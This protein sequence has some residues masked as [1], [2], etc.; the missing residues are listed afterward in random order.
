M[1]SSVPLR[2]RLPSIIT[3][4]FKGCSEEN[5][6]AKKATEPDGQA[7]P[8]WLSYSSFVTTIDGQAVETGTVVDLPLTYY[9]PSIP[10]GDGWTYGGAASPSETGQASPSST[11]STSTSPGAIPSST[12]GSQSKSGRTTRPESSATD[13]S[14]GLSTSRST[15]SDTSFTLSSTSP[16]STLSSASGLPISPSSSSASSRS[17]TQPSTPSPSVTI[18]L[19]S[20]TPAVSTI[21]VASSIS[22]SSSAI[23]SFVP[24]TSEATHSDSSLIPLLPALLVPL[25]SL[26]VLGL[27]ILLC[28]CHRKRTHSGYNSTLTATA[29]GFGGWLTSSVTRTSSNRWRSA[30]TPVPVVQEVKGEPITLP[31]ETSALLPGFTAQHHRKSSSINILDDEF[32][33]LI[34][35]NQTLLE[36]LRLGLGFQTPSSVASSTK[37]KDKTQRIISGNTLE[38]GGGLASGNHKRHAR[39]VTDSSGNA[40]TTSGNKYEPLADEMLFFR[41]PI[42]TLSSKNSRS[43][44]E[45]VSGSGGSGSGNRSAGTGSRTR[46]MTPGGSNVRKPAEKPP[47]PEGAAE[48]YWTT[49]N[50]Q[51]FNLGIPET[52]ETGFY[53]SS[54]E[55]GSG[56]GPKW[57]DGG[58]RLD[59]PIPPDSAEGLGLEGFT[60][61]F[62]VASGETEYHSIPEGDA[63]DVLDRPSVSGISRQLPS[64]SALF[65]R[66]SDS[67][68]H[69]SVSAFGSHPSTPPN[70]S[71]NRERD[72]LHPSTSSQ[73]HDRKS[74]EKSTWRRFSHLFSPSDSSPR[75]SLDTAPSVQGEVPVLEPGSYGE[76]GQPLK[77]VTQSSPNLVSRS[78]HSQQSQAASIHGSGTTSSAESL[79]DMRT[80][81]LRGKRS[82]PQFLRASL[83]GEMPPLPGQQRLTA[84]ADMKEDQPNQEKT[85]N[86]GTA[87]EEKKGWF[88]KW[89]S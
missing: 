7:L 6:I 40:T 55:D 13:S 59:F 83:L 42:T 19:T 63:E 66:E 56:R 28:F 15:T 65:A 51:S 24:G 10:L 84:T 86:E 11:L 70:S 80:R 73:S 21:P 54:V 49:E 53:P 25:I 71:P 85:E 1:A 12:T 32:V 75:P 29:G 35:S 14:A 46:T 60:N 39:T 58:D 27:L 62:S 61:R 68:R 77:D 22:S 17:D 5:E 43:T 2:C 88:G 26:L 18:S 82:Q 64:S 3:K 23:S 30:W 9:G 45:D 31:T 38:K 48:P 8:D 69:V 57:R 72:N 37:S 44:A 89:R 76:F 74:P 36:R 67:Y 34:K 50:L 16:L 87:A 33:E 41:K 4:S 52:P 78:T 79:A 81:A 20:S 47:L